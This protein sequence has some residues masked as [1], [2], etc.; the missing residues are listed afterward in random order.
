M[1]VKSCRRCRALFH[2][3]VGPQLCQ[4]CKRKDEEDFARVK[5][6]LYD[7]PGASMTTVC[8]ELDVTV[9]Q[10]QQYLRDGR[11]TVSKDSPIGIDCER[12]GT[13]IITGKYCD[14]CTT[15]MTNQFSS[16]SKGMK[17]PEKAKEKSG[18]KMRY[19]DSDSIRRRR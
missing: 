11:L 1:E 14:E 8:E 17:K 5:E 18:T 2:H 3:V 10:V 12:C 6:Y 7:N 19:L 15:T 13:R 16:A 9:R 4:K